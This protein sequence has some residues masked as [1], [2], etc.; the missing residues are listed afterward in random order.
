MRV[1]ATEVL[2]EMS[3]ELLKIGENAGGIEAR[4]VVVDACKSI[5]GSELVGCF[6]LPSS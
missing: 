5:T 3:T 4:K 2:H 1:H 6:R